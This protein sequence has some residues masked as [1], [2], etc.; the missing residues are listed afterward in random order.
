MPA[1]ILLIFAHPD[2]ESFV[3]AG[4]AR[5]YADSG[6]HIALVTATSGDAGSCGEPALCNEGGAARAA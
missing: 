4:L 6:A 2:D 1:R 5:R 3:A